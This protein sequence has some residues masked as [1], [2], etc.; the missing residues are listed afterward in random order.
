MLYLFGNKNIKHINVNMLISKIV[1]K[2]H[3]KT[4]RYFQFIEMEIN[5]I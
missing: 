1:L 2:M 4:K 3:F 5:W